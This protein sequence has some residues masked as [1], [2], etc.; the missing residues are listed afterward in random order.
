[1][2][3]AARS[4]CPPPPSRSRRAAAAAS[5]RADEPAD[6][7]GLDLP[8]G[9][10]GGLRPL[11]QPDLGDV[12]ERRS[13]PSRVALRRR[14]RPGMA[15]VAAVL[16]L[17][18]RRRHRRHG[19]DAYYGTPADPAPPASRTAGSTVRQV[20]LTD[21]V[22]RG[23]GRPRCRTCSGPRRRPTRCCGSSTSRPWPSAPGRPV[24]C[25]SSTAPSPR[26]SCTPARAGCR[27]SS[28]TAQRSTSPATPTCCWVSR[29]P[30]TWQL[31]HRLVEVRS[32][33]GAVPGTVE[34]WLALRGLRTLHLR[35][36]ARRPTRL[37]LAGRLATHPVVTA[38]HYPGFGGW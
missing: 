37:E 35:W 33:H 24:R 15:A 22:R 2:T 10:R 19:P 26:R 36:S 23:R 14:S 6:R 1:M 9:R 30:A 7:D 29:W 38:V 32:L 16:D 28:C 3:A 11:R 4:P 25:W 8:R 13:V 34:A 5:G 12:R 21:T 31:A 18:P 17:V 20:D 27:P